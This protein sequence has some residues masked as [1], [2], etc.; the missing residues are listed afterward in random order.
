[1]AVL[2]TPD[3]CFANLPDYPFPP[4]YLDLAKAIGRSGEDQ[5]GAKRAAPTPLAR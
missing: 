2:R 5:R 3:S 1:M 4:H